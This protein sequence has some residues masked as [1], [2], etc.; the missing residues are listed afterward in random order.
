V[1]SHLVNYSAPT[2]ILSAAARRVIMTGGGGG[3]P[4]DSAAA[5]VKTRRSAP[6]QL[7][8]IM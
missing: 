1:L 3:A 4:I 6:R 5:R 7:L 2:S 8:Q